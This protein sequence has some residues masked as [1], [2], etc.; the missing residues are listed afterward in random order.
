MKRTFEI[1]WRDELRPRWLDRTNIFD[2]LTSRSHC[3]PNQIIAVRDV[4]PEPGYQVITIDEHGVIHA[5]NDEARTAVL[6]AI[7]YAAEQR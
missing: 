7:R 2:F 4:T 3:Q 1:K 5:P 6:A